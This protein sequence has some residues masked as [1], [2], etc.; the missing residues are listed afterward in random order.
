ME[1]AI[2]GGHGKIA[3]LLG[4]Q[5]AREGHRAVGLIRKEEQAGELN[6]L[7]I[8]P[9]LI[10]LES[11]SAQELAERLKGFDAVV[12]AAGAGP[13]SG[14]ARKDTVDRGAAVLLADAAEAAGV[15][16]LLQISAMSVE[17]VRDGYHP[18]GMDAEFHAYLVAKLAVEDDLRARSALN[19]T[20]L[21]P[22]RLT[23]DSGTGDVTLKPSAERGDVTRADV[24]AVIVALLNARA[25]VNQV[26]ELVSG[27]TQVAE[28]VAALADLAAS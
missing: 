16:W 20:I 14:A 18:E 8:E 27:P 11:A 10:D 9:M 25:G 12:F 7:G 23:D 19:W 17:T 5:L 22:G 26:L 1:I 28:A 15:P 2:A 3:L 6:E 24:A 4:E 13:G 21:R